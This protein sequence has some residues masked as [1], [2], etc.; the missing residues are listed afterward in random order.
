[1][2]AQKPA[3]DQGH[4]G[5]TESAKPGAPA[6]RDVITP[7]WVAIQSDKA[8]ACDPPPRSKS[9]RKPAKPTIDRHR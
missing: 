1:M 9:D 2:P 4:E 3:P 6:N 5:A 7:D 8:L